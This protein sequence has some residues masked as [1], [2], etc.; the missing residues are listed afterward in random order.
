MGI[1]LG[2]S[3]AGWV[4]VVLLWATL[5]RRGNYR[6][7]ALLRRRLPRMLA[8]SVV[9]GGVV[10]GLAILLAP[11]FGAPSLLL[12]AGGLVAMVGVGMTSFFVLCQLT[13]A[14]DLK[15]SLGQIAGR[16]A[17]TPPGPPA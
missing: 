14:I 16:R 8:S 15:R 1:A 9:M 2:T 6:P 17:P 7:D 4:N 10:Y 12:R 3:L 13:G 5:A 11:A